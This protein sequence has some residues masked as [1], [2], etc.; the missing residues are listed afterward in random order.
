MDSKRNVVMLI[1]PDNYRDEEYEKPRAA[2]EAA[3]AEV[4]V[5]STAAGRCKGMLGGMAKADIDLTNA[6]LLARNDLWDA[7]VFVGGSGA[8]VFF[9][10]G[11]AHA[12]AREVATQGRVVGAICI[13]P[14]TLAYAG[15]LSGIEA[16]SFESARQALEDSGAVWTGRPVESAVCKVADGCVVVTA[17]GP[18][19]ADGFGRALVKALGL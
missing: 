14:T 16:T 6:L 11:E 3:G 2:L 12:L 1:A 15:L 17:N 5:A 18:Q 8:R 19:A 10:N 13:A 4:T 7:V 9:N